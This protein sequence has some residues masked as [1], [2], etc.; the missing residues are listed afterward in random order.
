LK[1]QIRETYVVESPEQASALMN[2]LRAE[3]LSHLKEPAS[4]TEVAKLLRE[5]PQRINYHLKALEKVGLVQRMG[6]RQVRNLVEVLYQSVARTFLLSEALSYGKNTLKKMKD[7]G[8]LLHLIHT[9]ERIKKDALALMEQVDQ[10]ETVPSASMHMQVYL[11]D[12]AERQQFVQDYVELVKQLISKYQT[13]ASGS[14]PYQV[15]LAVYP[16]LDP[17]SDESE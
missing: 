15:L 9:S 5:T 10:D 2:P 4:A 7:Q 1:Q 16:D 11:Q 3:I 6:T 12:E 17:G 13:K 14:H 8:S